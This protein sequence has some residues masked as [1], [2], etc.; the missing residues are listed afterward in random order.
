MDTLLG[1]GNSLLALVPVMGFAAPLIAFIVDTAKRAKLPDGYA[2]L[3]S[4]LLN[5]AVFAVLYFVGEA[6]RAQVQD[7]VQLLTQIAP[8]IVALF[9]SLLGTAKAHDLLS[10][11]GIGFS[12]ADAGAG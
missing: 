7:V 2:P 1:F 11:V 8:V 10:A 12:H 6:H 4:G 5:F 3:L 9:I